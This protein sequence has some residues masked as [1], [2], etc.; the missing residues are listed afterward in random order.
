MKWEWRPVAIPGSVIALSGML[1]GGILALRL[2][3][4][5]LAH[6]GW[7]HS[8]KA[9]FLDLAGIGVLSLGVVGLVLL[10][11]LADRQSKTEGE[12]LEAF[13]E[14]I[15][16]NVYFKDRSSRFLRISN[17]MANYC[18]LADPAQAVNKMDSDVFSAEHAGQAFADEQR[19][20]R[21][22]EPILG[23][24][25]KETW[26][27]GRESWV[28]TSKVPLK[29][30]RGRITGTM[31]ISRDITD[32]KQA[33][34]RIR[35]MALHDALTGLPNRTLLEDR[36]SQAIALACRNRKRVAVFMLDLDRFKNVNDSFGHYIGDRLLE[37]VSGRLRACL[38]ES[39]IVARLGGDEFVVALPMV[40]TD[41]EVRG[42][43]RK[44]LSALTEPFQIEGHELRIG[45]S[46]GVCEYPTHGE[47]S[48]ALLQAADTAMYEAKRN[49][50]GTFQFFT[51]DLTEATRRR[52]KLELD[53]R[54]ALTRNEFVLYYQPLISIA[55]GSITGVEALLRWQH[56]D[57][58][59]IFPNEFI[60]QLEDLGL[61]VDVGHWVLKTA[62]VQNAEWQK[63]GLPPVRI[64][65]N[66]SARQFYQG[67]IVHTV[68]KTLQESRLDPKWLELELT[69]S[70][71]LDDSE[72]TIKIM[73]ELKKLGVS[74]SLDDFGTGWS[75][76]SYLRQ[77]PID[78]IKIDRSF[79]RDLSTQPAAEAVVR[80]VVNLG[81]DLG[82]SCIAEGVET[83]EQLDYIQGQRCAEAQGFLFSPPV[84]EE[85]CR[86]ILR[87]QNVGSSKLPAAFESPLEVAASVNIVS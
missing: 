82:L 35:H 68:K 19:I 16:D 3:P 73:R 53:L 39:D 48:G 86:A 14:N 30:R 34:L 58:G 66:L 32:R 8:L 25:E 44:V 9:H 49:A 13:L 76:L 61:M 80:S 6:G 27:D 78:R 52:H 84:P 5:D 72:A 56:P 63:D 17:A 51:P 55:S 69:E 74:L 22:G 26:P 11:E 81:R 70:L 31:G 57:Q 2:I 20:I 24:E 59:L 46:M 33:E 10:R 21:S 43:V 71:T 50:R 15:P 45:A 28:L 29:D 77:F 75:S 87:S 54:H 7:L 18:G 4:S 62:C 38:R 60:P 47:N 42:V 36:L 83:A 65:V 1:L 37:S 67:N 85:S 40:D 79:L 41:K 64:A 12:L 23:V